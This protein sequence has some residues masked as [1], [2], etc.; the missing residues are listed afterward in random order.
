MVNKVTLIGHLGKDPE[1]RRLDNG[2]VVAK[3]SLATNESYKDKSGN[4]QDQT[5]WHDVVA[6]R[7]LAEKAER[8]FKKGK[9]VYIEGKLTTRKWEDK[10][11]NNRYT[12]EVVARVA[13]LLEKREGGGGSGYFPSANDA[14][15]MANTNTSDTAAAAQPVA[16]STTE[17][18]DP[19]ADDLPF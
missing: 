15:P 10:D 14:P 5:E 3:F 18:P 7:Y 2:A 1:V 8:D 11:G 9:L 6:W 16:A 12:T 4:W 13:N 17:T 19:A